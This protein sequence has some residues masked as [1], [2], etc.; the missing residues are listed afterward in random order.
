MT[1]LVGLREKQRSS[2]ACK[3]LWAEAVSVEMRGNT[4]MRTNIVERLYRI[5]EALVDIGE[6]RA[7]LVFGFVGDLV[8]L[9]MPLVLPVRLGWEEQLSA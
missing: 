6:E 8:A 1:P 9:Q 7:G 4:Q 5:E 3:M 2:K